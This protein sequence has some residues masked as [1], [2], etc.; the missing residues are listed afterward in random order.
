LGLG[1]NVLADKSTVYR[2]TGYATIDYGHTHTLTL[3]IDANGKVTGTVGNANF[4]KVVSDIASVDITSSSWYKG[5]RLV[6]N[7]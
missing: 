1:I 7:N 5:L 6:I 2:H 4:S 3:G